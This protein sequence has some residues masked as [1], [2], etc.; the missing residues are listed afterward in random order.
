[1]PPK[2]SSSLDHDLIRDLARLLTETNL[3]EIE[4]Q[5]AELR[6]RVA[7]MPGGSVQAYVP[8]GG[9]AAPAAETK[10]AAQ[11]ASAE[12]GSKAGVVPSPM[13]GT[14]YRSPD[15]DAKPFVEVGDKVKAGQTLLIVEAM[16]TMNQIPA[17]KAGTVTQIL[18]NDGQPVEYGEPLMVIE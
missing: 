3:T 14:V 2:K 18:V 16:K 11:I 10:T 8:A 4:I 12:A 17:P 15:P 5:G 13:V 6:V 7:R 9:T 1:M